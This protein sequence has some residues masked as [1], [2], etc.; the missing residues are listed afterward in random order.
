MSVEIN[1]LLSHMM[2]IGASDLHL[3][4]G[5]PPLFRVAGV[6][7]ETREFSTPLAPATVESLTQSLMTTKALRDFRVRQSADFG[8]ALRGVGRFRVNVFQQRGTMGVVIRQIPQEIPTIS[9]LELPEILAGLTQHN[10][11]LVLVTGPTGSGKSTTLAALVDHINKTRKV[12]IVSIEDPI[13]YFFTDNKASICQREIGLD[14]PSFQEALRGVLRQDP[15]VILLGE[16]RDKE[17]IRT[18][19]TAAETGHLVFSTLHTNDSAQAIDRIADTFPRSARHHVLAQLANVLLAV[20]NQQLIQRKGGK[21]L[22]AATEIMINNPLIAKNIRRGTTSEILPIIE[23]SVVGEKMQ[24]MNQSLCAL[25]VNNLISEEDAMHRSVSPDEL[26]QMRDRYFFMETY[27][28]DGGE[29][30]VPAE[31]VT[32]LPDG[33]PLPKFKNRLEELAFYQQLAKEREKTGGISITQLQAKEQKLAEER[34][35]LND[36][37]RDLKSRLETLKREVDDEEIQYRD[38]LNKKDSEIRLLEQKINRLKKEL[39]DRPS[40]RRGFFR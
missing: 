8:H 14:T 29:A 7:D 3:K 18:A 2:Q 24:S 15:D 31:R 4:V 1:E 25:W 37:L 35:W 38:L 12:H 22:I 5:R 21:G 13:E 34:D 16:M 36:Q 39:E 17:T 9:A 30:A 26:Q 10:Q 11:G 23:R 20:L 6:L 28:A 33:T 27:S 32:Q 19:L 40:K